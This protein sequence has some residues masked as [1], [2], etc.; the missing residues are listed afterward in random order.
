MTWRF[1]IQNTN[2]N[3][4]LSF[5]FNWKLNLNFITVCKNNR[6]ISLRNSILFDVIFNTIRFVK[7]ATYCS[8]HCVR[9]ENPLLSYKFNIFRKTRKSY[10]VRILFGLYDSIEIRSDMITSYREIWEMFLPT[11]K[12]FK[13]NIFRLGS[14]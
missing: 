2:N 1:S 10:M 11:V 14:Q 5:C 12:M 8:Y 3:K 7:T 9:V 4:K 13:G 6:L